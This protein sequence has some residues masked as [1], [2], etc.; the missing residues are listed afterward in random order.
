MLLNLRHAE[1]SIVLVNDSRMQEL[2]SNY[3]GIDKTTDVLSFPLL[4]ADEQ[5]PKGQYFL[6]GDIVINLHLA[7]RMGNFEEILLELLV[8]GLL[9]LVG[10]DHEKSKIEDKKM[11]K[12][13]ED[14]INAIKKMDNVS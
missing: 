11:K 9:H 5:P 2:N 1:L 8:H 4:E 14:M 7:S 3:R 10:F 13:A 12:A 6:L